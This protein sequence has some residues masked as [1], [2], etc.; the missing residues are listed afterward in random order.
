[1][2][3]FDDPYVNPDA[4]EQIVGHAKFRKA[5]ES[6]QRKSIV[7]LKNAET[8]D[9]KTLP[10]HGKPKIYIEGIDPKVAN[11]YGQV[12]KNIEE[13]EIAILRLDTPF[14]PREGL[15][16]SLFHA[17]D[18]DLKGKEKERLLGLLG[19]VPTVVDILLERPAVIPEIAEKSAGLLANF[20]ASDAAVL[21]VIFGRCTPNGK[22]PF[23]MP[24]SMEAVKKQKEDV[25]YDSENPLFPFGH[26]LTY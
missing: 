23:E 26:G 2:G 25:P 13:A 24:S 18:L 7:L 19:R 12:V 20:G 22:L 17:G 6:A 10:L 5:G 8:S 1:L 16:D 11:G 4:A 21:D 15:L 3:L 9:G 14:E